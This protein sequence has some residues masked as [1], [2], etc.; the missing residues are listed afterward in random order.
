MFANMINSYLKSNEE[1]KDNSTGFL[2]S[3]N[4]RVA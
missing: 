2:L 3:V 4:C 1:V